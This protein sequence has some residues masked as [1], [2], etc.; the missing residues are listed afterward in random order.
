[1]RLIDADKALKIAESYGTTHGTSLGRH[2]GIADTIHDEIAKLP[3]IEAESVRHGKWES[4]PIDETNPFGS[5]YKC[6]VCHSDFDF[7][8]D[9]IF[10]GDA[11]YCP[12]CGAKMDGG[13]EDEIHG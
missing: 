11:K 3:T 6:S 5:W 10:V 13:G 8:E 1:M 2:S 12:N 7:T 9:S 4:C